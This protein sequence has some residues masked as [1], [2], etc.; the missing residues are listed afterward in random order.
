MRK[1]ISILLVVL[2]LTGC[3]GAAQLPTDPTVPS[4]QSEPTDTPTVVDEGLLRGDV[5]TT[6]ANVVTGT[7][8]KLAFRDGV[9][10]S[11][12]GNYSAIN[13]TFT[14]HTYNITTGETTSFP[15]KE[16]NDPPCLLV[17]KDYVYYANYWSLSRCTRSGEYLGNFDDAF[18][19]NRITPSISYLYADSSGLY[20]W[21]RGGS[22]CHA[23]LYTQEHTDLMYAVEC[24]AMNDTDIFAIT[25]VG[26]TYQ[27]RRSAKEAL[28]FELIDL[29]FSPGMIYACNDALYMCEFDLTSQYPRSGL[30]QIIRYADGM[31]IRLPVYARFFQVLDDC[32]IYLDDTTYD[33]GMYSLKSYD[34]KTGETRLL[35]ESAYGLAIFEDRYIYTSLM[36]QNVLYD[37]RTGEIS[38]MP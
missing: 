24:F 3:T 14:L 12:V 5:G 21:N 34:L 22:L 38:Q 30:H 4:K 35:L 6:C 15:L 31:E 33:N 27:L 29:S 16:C 10:Y 20:Y 19:Q 26:D 18:E 9:L 23:N 28:S 8:G 2:L 7:D 32:L 25:S 37:W 13:P 36:H 11:V 1:V 17:T